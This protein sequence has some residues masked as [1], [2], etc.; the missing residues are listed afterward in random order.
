MHIDLKDGV[1]PI[2]TAAQSLARLIRRAQDTG[3]PVIVTQKGRPSAAIISIDLLLAL[4]ETATIEDNRA[5]A[6]SGN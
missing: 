3:A 2:S 6:T 1:V 4:C 5:G